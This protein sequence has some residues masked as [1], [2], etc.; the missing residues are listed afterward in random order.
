LLGSR[1]RGLQGWRDRYPQ[2]DKKKLIEAV[3]HDVSW[4]DIL[5]LAM[6]YSAF[7]IK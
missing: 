3:D 7:V 5:G 4:F 2:I 1:R 6:R